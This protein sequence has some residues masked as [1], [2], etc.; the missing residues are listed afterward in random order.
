M[1]SG[2][3]FSGRGTLR[4]QLRLNQGF[5]HFVW[6]RLP[7]CLHCMMSVPSRLFTRTTR[8]YTR[9]QII[10]PARAYNSSFY[11]PVATHWLP[12]RHVRLEQ[13]LKSTQPNMHAFENL[14]HRPT[15]DG[16]ARGPELPLSTCPRGDS[17]RNTADQIDEQ[18]REDGHRVWGFAIYRCTYSDD[19][20]WETFLERIHA[21]IWASMRYYNGLD[22]LEE[23]RFRLTVIEDANRFDG[24]SRQIVREHFKEWRKRA[25]REEQGTN[26]EIEARREKPELPDHPY[27]TAGVKEDSNIRTREDAEGVNLPPFDAALP[28]VCQAGSGHGYGQRMVAA[29]YKS[30]VQ[31]DEASLQSI[32]STETELL[33]EGE[34]WVNLIE[35]DWEPETAAAQREQEKID[36]ARWGLDPE[37][38]ELE[39]EVFPEIDGCTEENVGWMK[40]HYES[41]IPECYA[42][43]MDQNGFNHNYVRPPDM[44]L[45]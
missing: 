7:H 37:V 43:M 1:S 11:G 45:V 20:A 44:P 3:A 12:R 5:P 32:V 33:E 2:M 36:Y 24:A 28:E 14:T 15:D 41:L 19:A 17:S 22:L 25:V 30:C 35:G 4:N 34:A 38:Y 39:V 18:L 13:R 40:V 8:I 31:V 21:S 23:D 27:G 10:A 29:R 16:A 42:T 26:E 9:R 6:L